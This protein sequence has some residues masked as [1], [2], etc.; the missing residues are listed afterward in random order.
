MIAGANSIFYGKA[1]LTA[2]NADM[3]DDA[4]LFEAIGRPAEVRPA[5][6]H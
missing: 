6:A 2:P 1:L 3:G 5:S 4:A